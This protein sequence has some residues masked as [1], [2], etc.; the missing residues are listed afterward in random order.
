MERKMRRYQILIFIF[1]IIGALALISAIFPKEGLA[2]GPLDM[3]FATLEEVLAPEEADEERLSPEELL[4]RRKQAVLAAEADA[5]EDYFTNDPARFYLPE[6]NVS[7]FDGL[8]EALEGA[9]TSAVRIVHYGDSQ[10]EEDR[11]TSVIRD[12]LQKRFGG[13][14]QGYMPART[15][16]TSSIGTASDAELERFMVYATKAE[17]S[18]YGPYGDFVQL[19][20]TLTLSYYQVRKKERGQALFNKLTVLAGNVGDAG[21][22]ISSRGTTREYKA[23]DDYVRAVFNLPDSSSRVSLTLSGD[24]DIYGVLMDNSCGVSMDNVA[25]RGCSGLVFT[26][27][28]S[29][30]LR[31][32]YKDENVRLIML[33]YGGN[34]VPYT[35]TSKAISS[36]CSS[37]RRQIAYLQKLAPEA[38][39]IFIGPSDMSTSIKGKR[40]TYPILPEMIDS[41]K[42]TATSSGAAYW[43][44]YGAM[45]GENSMVDWVNANPSLAG[46]DYVHF[47]PRG[48]VRIGEMFYD[49]FKLYYDYYLWRKKNE[50]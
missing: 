17:H 23:G 43:D 1:S 42:S 32:F 49:S 28:S 31:R 46:S 21:L 19:D 29:A 5:F 26:Q 44:I 14:G 3:R 20:T 34:S 24:A 15:H 7:F 22:K 45:G 41:L 40:Q 2:I 12:S 16:Y 10:I 39:I 11:I 6:G 4:E 8:F 50:E 25:M 35:K 38:K 37:L 18:A 48:S 36:Y 9:D 13:D 30:Q 47:T 33:Q 27:M